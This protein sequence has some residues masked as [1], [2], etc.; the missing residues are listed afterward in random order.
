MMIL[1]CPRRWR[2]GQKVCRFHARRAVRPAVISL[3]FRAYI[4]NAP[5]I[6]TRTRVYFDSIYV[7]V[8]VSIF[9]DSG[10]SWTVEKIS[11]AWILFFFFLIA[12]KLPIIIRVI[13]WPRVQKDDLQE[14]HSHFVFFMWDCSSTTG[15]NRP[16]HGRRGFLNEDCW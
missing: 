14:T 2:E 12:A 8:P 15:S 11:W 7:S 13:R 6:Y 4:V 3:K 9:R 1:E 10:K 5:T 16:H